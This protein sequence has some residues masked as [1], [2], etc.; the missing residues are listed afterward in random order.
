MAPILGVSQ[1][2][3]LRVP[4]TVLKYDPYLYSEKASS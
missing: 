3:Y 4:S 1:P 2:I